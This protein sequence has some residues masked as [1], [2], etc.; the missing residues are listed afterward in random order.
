MYLNFE[1]WHGCENDFVVTKVVGSDDV[2]LASISRQAK[3]ICRRN[4]TGIGADGI[5]VMHHEST[6]DLVPQKITIINSDGSNAAICGNGIRC[7]ALSVLRSFRSEQKL[8]DLPETIEFLSGARRV[9]CSFLGNKLSER[10]DSWPFI[11]VNMGR[12]MVNAATGSLFGEAQQAIARVAAEL[13][14]PDLLRDFGVCDIG[15]K[16]L[17]IFLDQIT[18][19]MLHRVGP[20]FQ[21][22]PE[23]DGIN[24][25]LVEAV[26]LEDK[27][28]VTFA[29]LLGHRPGDGFRALVWERGAG[30]TAA[31]GSGACAIA[32][33]AIDAGHT[34]SRDWVAVEMPGGHLFVKQDDD[35][36]LAGPG[37]LVFTGTIE[38]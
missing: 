22:C 31:C 15:N 18:R 16:H 2:V 34:S 9:S 24:V 14:M 33:C 20:A 30:P 25:H 6:K 29:N 19:E 7:V 21:H 28:K 4:G 11:A 37:H 8:K 36:Q 3:A 35:S 27:Q 17:V 26:A 23:W 1:K 5:I 13:T 32:A 10:V 38:I 12:A